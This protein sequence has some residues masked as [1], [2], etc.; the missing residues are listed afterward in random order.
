MLVS[1]D[2][3]YLKFFGVFSLVVIHAAASSCSLGLTD[4]TTRH[5]KS[6]TQSWRRNPE[7][8]GEESAD[9]E[10]REDRKEQKRHRRTETLSHF[11]L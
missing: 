4:D 7:Y 11:F 6:N 5:L 1:A 10:Q 2:P 3:L 8:P 9:C